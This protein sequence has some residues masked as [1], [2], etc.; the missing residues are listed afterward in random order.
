MKSSW[1]VARGML[2]LCVAAVTVVGCTAQEPDHRFIVPKALCGVTVPTDALS[3]LLPASGERL[4]VEHTGSLDDGSAV[5]GVEVDEATVLQVSGERIDPGDSARHILRSRLM[6]QP[7]KSAQDGSIAYAESAA[8][9]L[10]KC[11]GAHAE[12]DISTL[13]KVLEP[14]RP[15]EPAMKDLILGYTAS[16]KGQRPCEP[17]EG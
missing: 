4:T 14:G 15:D 6:M 8:V 10:I 9:S 1:C 12:E 3:Q 11:R 17:S 16:L 13:I 2:L 7:E 5:C